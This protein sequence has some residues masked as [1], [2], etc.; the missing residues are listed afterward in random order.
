MK[1]IDWDSSISEFSRFLKIDKNLSS[2]TIE[3]YIRDITRFHFYITDKEDGI[4]PNLIE[5]KH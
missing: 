5:Y 3:A 1:T 4:S 2:N